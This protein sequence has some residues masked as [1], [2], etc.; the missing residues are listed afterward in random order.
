M[1]EPGRLFDL[2]GRVALITGGSRGLGEDMAE[3]LAAAG[4][5]LM[6]V[7]RREEWLTP[8]V[9]R[10]QGLGFRCAGVVC[11]VAD[12]QS[13]TAAV[14]ETLERYGQIDI[15][16]NNA[17]ISWGARAEEMPLERWRAVLD[18]NLTGAFLMA[19]A[20]GR[21]MLRRKQGSIINISSVAG[22][23]ALPENI[24]GAAYCAAKGGLIAMTRELAAKWARDGVRVNAIAPGFFASRMSERVLTEFQ[25]V[26]ERAI[27]MGRIGR[28]GEL[29]GAAVFLA[30]DASSFI[31]GHTLVVDGGAM[32]V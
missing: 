6:L 21:E 4:A 18:V 20:A 11:D 10:L 17:G 30:S 12:P 26:L 22:L 5:S 28:P 7:A 8:A 31:T 3:G 15:L 9:D 19:Q 27:P 13:V 29:Q 1:T 25:P 24:H 14:A 32:A 23:A 16:L 2:T